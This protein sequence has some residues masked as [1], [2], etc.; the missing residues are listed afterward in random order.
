[1]QRTAL[2]AAAD[3]E[4]YMNR[5]RKTTLRLMSL[6]LLLMLLLTACDGY[7]H[8]ILT[9]N[10][11]GQSS[12]SIMTSAP[13]AVSREQAESFL[14][15]FCQQNDFKCWP[16]NDERHMKL[17]GGRSITLELKEDPSTKVLSLRI[18]QFGPLGPTLEYKKI[19]DALLSSIPTRFPGAITSDILGFQ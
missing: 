19:R 14:E 1:M 10:P 11:R 17:C 6:I 15:N 2:R 5:G 4:C 7:R 18:A 12:E 16:F 13:G 9:M 3:A 8:V